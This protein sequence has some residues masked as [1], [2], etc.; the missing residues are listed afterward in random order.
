MGLGLW[1]SPGKLSP[2]LVRNK[3]NASLELFL[4][5][6]WKEMTYVSPKIQ[7]VLIKFYSNHFFVGVS[8]LYIVLGF[9]NLFYLKYFL[10]WG[11]IHPESM[12]PSTLCPFLFL[13][14]SLFLLLVFLLL[15]VIHMCMY[16]YMYSY[17]ILRTTIRENMRHLNI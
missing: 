1:F 15:P 9:I 3:S 13:S 4:F 8:L 2:F 6:S 14:T 11:H 7:N 12:H 16:V 5:L 10:Y 17:R